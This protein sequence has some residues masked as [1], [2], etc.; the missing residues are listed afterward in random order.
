MLYVRPLATVLVLCCFML[1]GPLAAWA[2]PGS[3]R[4]IPQGSLGLLEGDTEVQ[5]IQSEIP[6]PDGQL[7]MCHGEC[8]VQTQG[9]QFV[10]QDEAVFAVTDT[11]KGIELNVQKGK[12]DFAIKP[13]ARSVSIVTAHDVIQI[14]ETVFTASTQSVVS[15]SVVVTDTGS[16][17]DVYQGGLRVLANGQPYS[18]QSGKSLQLAQAEVAGGGSGTG[19]GASGGTR[20]IG[21]TIGTVI[22]GGAMVG[23]VAAAAS[24]DDDE[25]TSPF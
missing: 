20:K 15:G 18:V 3:A 17:L 7:F 13:D 21:A 25:P 16:T 5:T 14:Q 9:L 22:A 8:L 6:A 10:A 24:D 12:V 2:G 23:V 19:S 1:A 11:Q 4:I